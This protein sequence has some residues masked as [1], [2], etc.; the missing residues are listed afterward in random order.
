MYWGPLTTEVARRSHS[1]KEPGVYKVVAR[2]YTSGCFAERYSGAGAAVIRVM[3]R[4]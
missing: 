3:P 4:P 1:Y 2:A